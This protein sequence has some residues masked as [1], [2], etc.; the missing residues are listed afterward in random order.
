MGKLGREISELLTAKLPFSLMV[1]GKKKKMF[2]DFKLPSGAQFESWEYA[3]KFLEAKNAIEPIPR[4][5]EPETLGEGRI[6]YYAAAGFRDKDGELVWSS[7]DDIE[8]TLILQLQIFIMP[9]VLGIGV[10][11]DDED[12]SE[13][14]SLKK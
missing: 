4:E 9:N 2:F 7:P 8:E 10:K 6:R 13:E 14:D 12:V 3:K 5:K 1:C 11:D